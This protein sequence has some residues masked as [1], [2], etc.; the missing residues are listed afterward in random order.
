MNKTTMATFRKHEILRGK[1]SVSR[2]FENG[3]TVSRHPLKLV[4]VPCDGQGHLSPARVLISVPRKTF[5][6]AHDRNLIKRRIREAYRQLKTSFYEELEKHTLCIDLGLI[7]TGKEIATYH[8]ISQQIDKLLAM[9][10][11]HAEKGT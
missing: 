9:V 4:W 8:E 10:V 11:R 6:K 5:R 7:Y 3:K 2:L 1:R